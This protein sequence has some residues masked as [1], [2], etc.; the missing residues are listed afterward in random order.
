MSV[1]LEEADAYFAE[2]L[3]SA[4]WSG[5]DEGK[6]RAALTMAERQITAVAGSA[7]CREAI[8]EQAVYVV[9]THDLQSGGK[10]VTSQS[11]DGVGSQSF[12]YLAA[13]SGRYA[14]ISPEAVRLLNAMPVGSLRLSHG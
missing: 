3:D 11:L 6:R 10:V 5:L 8:F 9:R 12:Q 4:F 13:R 7:A 1:T 2:H 14:G